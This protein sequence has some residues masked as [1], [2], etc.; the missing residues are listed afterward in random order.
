MAQEYCL[1]F[2]NEGI[3]AFLGLTVNFENGLRYPSKRYFCH[4]QK[5][6]LLKTVILNVV[7]DPLEEETRTAG[8]TVP[9]FLFLLTEALLTRTTPLLSQLTDHTVV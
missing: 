4:L 3:D 6:L 5:H 2:V 1:K 9:Q 7:A 8:Q